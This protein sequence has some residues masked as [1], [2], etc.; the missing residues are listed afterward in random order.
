MLRGISEIRAF[1]RT[2]RTPIHFISPTPFNLLGIDRW[3]V[4]GGSWGSTLALAYAEAHPDRVRGLVM[5]SVF[6]GT[7]DE[8]DWAFGTGLAASGRDDPELA[9]AGARAHNR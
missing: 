4:F 5:R 8:L 2:N 9:M 7:R 6:L 3:V 1:L